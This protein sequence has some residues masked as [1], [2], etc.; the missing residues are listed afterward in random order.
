M[1]TGKARISLI[2]RTSESRFLGEATR[3][4]NTSSPLNTTL[5]KGA[6]R[7]V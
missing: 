5:A 2:F 4:G 1:I 6:E 7:N 3:A